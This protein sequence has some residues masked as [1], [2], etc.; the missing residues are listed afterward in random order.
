MD[1][2]KLTPQQ[3]KSFLEIIKRKEEGEY[4]NDIVLDP[5]RTLEEANKKQYKFWNTQPVVKLNEFIVK[6]GPVV[7]I[8]Q[9]NIPQEE[10]KISD[11]YRWEVLDLNNEDDL[12]KITKFIQKNYIENESSKFRLFY[13]KE[14]IKWAISNQS[15]CLGASVIANGRLGGF[16]SARITNLQVNDNIIKAGEVNFLC[17]HPELRAKGMAPLLIKELNRRLNLQ[18]IYQ[19]YYTAERYVPKPFASMK[20]L[21]R[22]LNY[23]KLLDLEFIA[24]DKKAKIKNILTFYA[25]N[26]KMESKFVKMEREH[27]VDAH[28]ILTEYM[29]KYNFHHIYT[30]EEFEHCFQNSDIMKSYVVIEDNKVVDFA[31]YYK[32]Q[33]L[34]IDENLK[35]KHKFINAAYLYMYT[36][37]QTT[38]FSIIKNLL[39]AAK[40][41]GLDVF[42]ATNIMENENILHELKFQEGTGVLHH[43]LYNWK[44]ADM[45]PSQICAITL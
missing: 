2:T 13:T 31:S 27:M 3:K 7:Q 22:P 34:V 18:N 23:K 5:A 32:L 4:I 41:E 42:N 11:N 15:Y 33:S 30:Y 39:I 12:D 24:E 29:E 1:F 8:E 21:H 10:Y 6:D 19:G 36:S 35:Q 40:L 16:I 44:C 38:S 43:Y 17:V 45:K 26:D 25:V 28:K 9:N 37:Q 14:F 20:Y